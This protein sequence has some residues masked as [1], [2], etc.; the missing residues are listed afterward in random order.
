MQC[1]ARRWQRV[2]V[3]VRGAG[4]TPRRTDKR[5]RDHATNAEPFADYLQWEASRKAAPR[6]RAPKATTGG[7]ASAKLCL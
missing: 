2:I 3:A 6:T 4:E 1:L 5:P 7:A